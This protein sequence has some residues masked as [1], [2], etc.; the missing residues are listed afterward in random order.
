VACQPAVGSRFSTRP[1][2]CRRCC[3]IGE[4]VGHQR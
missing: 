4:P 2:G 1:I 3:R